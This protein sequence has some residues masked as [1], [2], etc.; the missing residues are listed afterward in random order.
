MSI[1]DTIKNQ[2]E[3]TMGLTPN[4]GSAAGG[5]DSAIAM[6]SELVS[7]SGGIGGLVQ[8]FEQH[9]LGGIMQSWISSGQNLPISS[10][11]ISSVIG[12]DRI[13][14][15]ASKFGMTPQDLEQ[16]FSTLLPQ[17]IDAL[18][19]HGTMNTDHFSMANLMSMGATA[20]KSLS[21]L[22]AILFTALLLS[23]SNAMAL[24]ALDIN[25]A[26]VQ[27]LSNLP[28]IG[29]KTAQQIVNA[30]P[31]HTVAD[32]Q[33]VKGIGAAK[34]AKIKDL[35]QVN[36]GTATNAAPAAP[37]AKAAP[38]IAPAA[39]V[40]AAPVQA[41]APAQATSPAQ[42][43]APAATQNT[44]NTNGRV[45]AAH[46]A[47]LTAG[48]TL[49]VNT[50]SIQELEKIPGIGPAKAQAITMGRPFASIED[51]KRV[52]GIKDATLAKIRPYVTVQ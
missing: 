52:K 12:Q 49:N 46:N 33:T 8:N 44:A 22:V 35:V 39:P 16:K 24:A 37:V 43:S 13:A 31:Y 28:G 29:A 7:Q 21:V 10:S 14:A 36:G 6:I 38:V 18:T 34:F 20:L 48:A 15:I 51:L 19:P 4:A 50:A 25:T 32:L 41:S 17:A 2:V 11:Q 30:R 45:H 26:T 40:A 23:T 47:K 27:E 42:A 3:S 5:Q 1:M 9:G